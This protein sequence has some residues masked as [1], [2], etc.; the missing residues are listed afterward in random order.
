MQGQNLQ[1][2][3]N[4]GSELLADMRL[5]RMMELAWRMLSCRTVKDAADYYWAIE[6]YNLIEGMARIV[7]SVN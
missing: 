3:P 4:L 7:P 6:R 5:Q 1:G 2:R